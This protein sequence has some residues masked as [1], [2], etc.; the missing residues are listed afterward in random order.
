MKR[1]E[2]PAPPGYQ[3]KD[4]TLEVPRRTLSALDAAILIMHVLKGKDDPMV[5]FVDGGRSFEVMLNEWDHGKFRIDTHILESALWSCNMLDEAG[6]FTHPRGITFKQF[7]RRVLGDKGN[8]N[9]KY[10]YI[11]EED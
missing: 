10:N 2:P 5:G 11:I 3:E 4:I 8:F 7:V 9:Y 1:Q 6:K